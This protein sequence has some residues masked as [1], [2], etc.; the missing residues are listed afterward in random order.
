M[1]APGTIQAGD[2]E[3]TPD[4]IA[5]SRI[6]KTS[7]VEEKANHLAACIRPSWIGVATQG[8]TTSNATLPPV[9]KRIQMAATPMRTIP[10]A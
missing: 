9:A 7:M 4:V 1:W 8:R 6:R 2:G 3:I 5:L 10:L